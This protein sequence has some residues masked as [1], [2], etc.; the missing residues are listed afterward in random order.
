MGTCVSE[1]GK[2]TF[3]FEREAAA[4]S[5]D[6]IAKSINYFTGKNFP[7]RVRAGPRD[8]RGWIDHRQRCQDR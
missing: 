6:K 1:E 5:A 8:H 2:Y 3:V 4:G 7:V